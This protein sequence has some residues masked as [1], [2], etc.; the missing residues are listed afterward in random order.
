MIEPLLVKYLAYTGH[1]KQ[2]KDKQYIKK[3]AMYLKKNEAFYV[4]K[5]N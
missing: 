4:N 5:N 2:A 3:L 1:I